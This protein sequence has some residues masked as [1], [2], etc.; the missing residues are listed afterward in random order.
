MLKAGTQTTRTD[1]TD[2]PIGPG[3]AYVIRFT[4]GQG[5]A[6]SFAA[7][8]R[9]SNDWFF[10]P[11]PEGIPLY[12]NGRPLSGDITRLVQLWDAGTELDQEPALGDATGPHQPMR[13][14]GEKDPDPL[15]R[16]VPVTVRLGDGRTFVRPEVAAM[17]SVTL[18]PGA[19]QQFTLRIE[20]I[21]TATT[22]VTSAGEFPVH[23]SPFA[24]T[25]H[26]APGPLFTPGVP[27]RENGL[28]ALAETG[29]PD[30]LGTALRNTRGAAT[31]VSPGVFVLHT[32]PAPLF[33]PGTADRELGL[34]RLAEDG[35]HTALRNALAASPPIGA[36]AT[37]AFDT[38]SGAE[39]AG[40]AVPGQAYELVVR[41]VPGDAISFATM[42]G[43]SN[44]WFFATR[45]EGIALFHGED[46]RSCDVT[47]DVLLYDLG[48][49]T[50]EE[51]DVG[52]STAPQQ[53][54]PDT[55]RPDRIAEVREVSL[56]RYPVPVVLHLRVTLTPR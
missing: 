48:T 28:E 46:P 17:I 26:R 38:P 15:V 9:E 2:G 22:L 25:V 49:E 30:P 52:P 29:A 27:A 23:V 56:E 33:E 21:S 39:A 37:G 11:G 5:H 10:A 18:T 13:E 54:A 45:P 50:D 6:L 36:S 43:M 31:A 51:L 16:E 44:D 8:L 3:E 40:P 53:P 55:G 7:M 35:D 32:L 41:G 19:D 4:A 42:F 14:Y 12:T 1:L 24:W 34:E 47:S 20:N